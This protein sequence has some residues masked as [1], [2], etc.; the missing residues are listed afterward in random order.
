[1]K[2]RNVC[3][4]S[5]PVQKGRV[6]F[7]AITLNKTDATSSALRAGWTLK[8]LSR[9]SSMRHTL[10]D[11]RRSTWIKIKN[12]QYTQAEGRHELFEEMRS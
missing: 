4:D 1:M 3:E 2:E 6:S 5:Y 8:E 9:S 10:V 12:P 7:L 11:E